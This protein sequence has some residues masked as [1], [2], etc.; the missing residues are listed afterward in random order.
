MES[1][2]GEQPDKMDGSKDKD[3]ESRGRCDQSAVDRPTASTFSKEGE[4]PKKK[5]K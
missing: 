1:S 3:V 2:D 5:T 4:N